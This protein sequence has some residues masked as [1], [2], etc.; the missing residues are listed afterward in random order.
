[1]LRRSSP[2]HPEARTRGWPL[3]CRG[4]SRQAA[5]GFFD[6]RS[7]CYD[8][9][10]SLSWRCQNALHQKSQSP[11]RRLHSSPFAELDPSIESI[12][13]VTKVFSRTMLTSACSYLM[14]GKTESA[15]SPGVMRVIETALLNDAR[16]WSL[17]EEE[18]ST[19]MVAL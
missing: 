3:S 12:Q 2:E 6:Q 9:G 7:T 1:M 8:D 13:K 4:A 16:P 5:R 11:V 18:L 17:L 10:S 15:R 14:N 19:R